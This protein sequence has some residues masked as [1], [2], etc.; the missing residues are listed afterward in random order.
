MTPY[1]LRE[2]AAARVLV[3]D[4]DGTLVRLAV[5]WAALRD[6]LARRSGADFSGGLDAGLRAVRER[7]EAL[8]RKLCDVVADAEIAGCAGVNAP[9]EIVRLL[10]LALLLKAPARLTAIV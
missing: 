8:F 4:F 6:D 3:V 9:L 2:I 5:D 10:R 7:D 1:M